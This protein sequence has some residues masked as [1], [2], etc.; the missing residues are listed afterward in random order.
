MLYADCRALRHAMERIDEPDDW[1]LP[2]SDLW[3]GARYVVHLRCLRCT[4]HRAIAID[5]RG[6]LLVARY[7]HPEGYLLAKGEPRV[8]PEELR[9]WLAGVNGARRRRRSAS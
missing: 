6:N 8:A 5:H 7:Q 4:T 9:L 1:V 3:Y 2:N